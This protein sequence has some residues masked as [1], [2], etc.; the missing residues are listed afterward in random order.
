MSK[1]RIILM[2]QKFIYDV[3]YIIDAC[4]KMMLLLGLPSNGRVS[5]FGH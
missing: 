2:L 4:C 1:F 5:M 3:V